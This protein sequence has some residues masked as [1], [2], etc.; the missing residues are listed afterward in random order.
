LEPTPPQEAWEH[1]VWTNDKSLI[2][3]SVD[4]LQKEGIKVKDLS[5]IDKNFK[6]KQEV[7]D[8]IEHNKWGMASDFL[9]LE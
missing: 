3:R 6:L 4:K 5:E 7:N 9:R 2:P 1:I 8:L